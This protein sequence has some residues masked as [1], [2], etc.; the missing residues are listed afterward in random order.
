MVLT[1][2]FLDFLHSSWLFN[3][4]PLSFLPPS[5][6][7]FFCLVSFHLPLSETKFLSPQS[8]SISKF[9]FILL[10]LCSV[11]L[12]FG[13]IIHSTQYSHREDHFRDKGWANVVKHERIKK[14]PDS[15]FYSCPSVSGSYLSGGLLVY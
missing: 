4:F 11:C 8:S 2:M 10:Y 7:R 12:Y 6:T 5:N 15:D 1:Q 9:K 14:N 13:L 3:R